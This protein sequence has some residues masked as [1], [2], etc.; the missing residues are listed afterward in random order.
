MKSRLSAVL[1]GAFDALPTTVTRLKRA[2][3]TTCA[4]LQSVAKGEV[5]LDSEDEKAA[6]EAERQEQER[7]FADLLT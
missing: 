5:D 1:G 7:D 3:P 2:R 4:T 6:H